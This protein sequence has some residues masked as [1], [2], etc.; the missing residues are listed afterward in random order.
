MVNTQ[1]ESIAEMISGM[2][3]QRQSHASSLETSFCASTKHFVEQF[4]DADPLR[5]LEHPQLPNPEAF[6]IGAR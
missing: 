4:H 5:L 2:E 1:I 6:Q 3:G